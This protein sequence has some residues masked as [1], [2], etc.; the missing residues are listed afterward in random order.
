M[1]LWVTIGQLQSTGSDLSLVFA[2]QMYP[3][4][5]QQPSQNESMFP[6]L[7]VLPLLTPSCLRNLP[8][9][10]PPYILRHALK[11]NFFSVLTASLIELTEL[12]LML[13]IKASICSEDTKL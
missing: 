1:S 11:L 6:M 8:S 2:K 5:I 3:A 4:Q 10:P 9:P 13:L 12:R 7:L